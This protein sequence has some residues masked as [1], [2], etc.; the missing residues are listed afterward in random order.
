MITPILC[1]PEKK[2]T[3]PKKIPYLCLGAT[4]SGKTLLLRKLQGRA[5]ID[6]TISS[7][8]TIG[9]SLYKLKLRSGDTIL[10]RELGGSIAPLWHHYYKYLKKILFVIDASNLCQISASG[11]LLYSTLTEPNLQQAEVTL[12]KFIS[13]WA[14]CINKSQL[15]LQS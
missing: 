4:N 5:R 8:P 11:V 9:S 10:I 1:L 14:R 2:M 7:V 13:L 15:L 3:S 6:E 12:K